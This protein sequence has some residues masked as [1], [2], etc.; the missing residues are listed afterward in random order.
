MLEV[1]IIM[2]N[3][4]SYYECTGIAS[5]ANYKKVHYYDGLF[6]CIQLENQNATKNMKIQ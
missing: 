1:H 4:E 5:R 3:G 6:H 2:Y